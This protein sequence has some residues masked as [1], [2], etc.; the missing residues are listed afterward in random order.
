MIHLP[1]VLSQAGSIT[2]IALAAAR[3]LGV[4]LVW[5]VASLVLRPID[6]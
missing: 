5:T 6:R 4:R 3:R 2:R 1:L